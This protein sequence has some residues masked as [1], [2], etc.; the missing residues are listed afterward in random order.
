MPPLTAAKAAAAD[1]DESMVKDAVAGVIAE[2]SKDGRCPETAHSRGG[3]YRH[4]TA[5]TA[6]VLIGYQD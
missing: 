1:I 2:R 6:V 3:D 5:A 4:R